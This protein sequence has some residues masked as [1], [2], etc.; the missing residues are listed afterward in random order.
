M[1][2]ILNY[3]EVKTTGGSSINIFL[4]EAS[5]PLQALMN[6]IKRSGDFKSTMKYNNDFKIEVKK[7]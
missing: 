4:T 2:K 5:S 1:G 6:L 7:Y 3:Y